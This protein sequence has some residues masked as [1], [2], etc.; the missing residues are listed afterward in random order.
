[1]ENYAPQMPE[2]A[3]RLLKFVSSSAVRMGQLI[4]DLLHFSRLGRQQLSKQS[5]NVS[6]LVQEVLEE[7]GKDQGDRSIELLVGQMPD[8][9]GDPS[10][11]KQVFV[12]LLS[13]AYKFTRKKE[14]AMIEV[15]W[16]Q[17][18]KEGVYFVKDNGAGFDMKHAHKLFDVFQRLHRQD[19]F[20]G[21]GVGL[22]TVQR[23]IN[24]HGGRIWAE[25]AVDKGAEFYFTLPG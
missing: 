5:V 8:T 11:L 2:E 4:D 23:I 9:V 10:L 22:S 16:R 24:R 21:T 25:A 7:L 19:E 18:E 6:S 1:M 13:N 20:E 12:N 14:K 3:R 17:D 15:G